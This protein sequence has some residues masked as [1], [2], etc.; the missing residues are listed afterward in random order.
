VPNLKKLYLSHNNFVSIPS[1]IFG[2]MTYLAHLDL[3]YQNAIITT[4]NSYVPR[5]P[6]ITI[7]EGLL[8]PEDLF[9]RLDNLLF[10]DLSHTK[11]LAS[12][13]KAFT[14]LGAKLQQ[15]S[16]CYTSLPIIGRKMFSNT[17]LKVLDISGNP[18]K[19]V[20]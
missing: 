15:L 18:G 11:L 2:H 7:T 6:Y 20:V 12:S 9:Y 8:L 4:P 5:D 16:L 17:N 14:M 3:S 1:H 19:T 10:L 13:V